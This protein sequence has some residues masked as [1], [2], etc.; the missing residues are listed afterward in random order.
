[1]TILTTSPVVVVAVS[2]AV[3]EAEGAVGPL[4]VPKPAETTSVKME[5]RVKGPLLLYPAY[6][7]SVAAAGS[8]EVSSPQSFVSAVFVPVLTKYLIVLL[9]TFS[10]NARHSDLFC[11]SL[12]ECSVSPA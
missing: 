8:V 4:Y 9:T 2:A 3:E 5:A 6:C 7:A 1:M 12:S 10:L 11:P